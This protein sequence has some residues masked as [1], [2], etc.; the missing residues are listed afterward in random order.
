MRLFKAVAEFARLDV[1]AS[2][3]PALAR[4]E[5]DLDDQLERAANRAFRDSFLIGAGLAAAALLTLV[6]PPRRRAR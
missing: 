4:L 1:D 5:R 6:R 3:R 2:D